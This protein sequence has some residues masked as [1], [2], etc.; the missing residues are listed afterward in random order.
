MQEN[1][2]ISSLCIFIL[3]LPLLNVES[4]YKA[5]VAYPDPLLKELSN[6]M[7]KWSIRNTENIKDE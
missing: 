3:E 7:P 1:N 5:L 6:F 4:P 2:H